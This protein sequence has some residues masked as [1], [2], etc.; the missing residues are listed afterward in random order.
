MKQKVAGRRGEKLEVRDQWI[1]CEKITSLWERAGP[2][3]VKVEG[4]IKCQP[5]WR[6]IP[7]SHS[8]GTRG[9]LGSLR[10]GKAE[11]R[12]LG[13]PGWLAPPPSLLELRETWLGKRCQQNITACHST[14][15]ACGGGTLMV[16][17]PP[18]PW[19]AHPREQTAPSQASQPSAVVGCYPYWQKPGWLGLGAVLHPLAF[20]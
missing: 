20:Y 13:S 5:N 17:R 15:R 9:W 16:P 8:G 18:V 10:E 14:S 6:K 4:H 1:P 19:Q 12:K 3:G 11:R 7:E 2:H